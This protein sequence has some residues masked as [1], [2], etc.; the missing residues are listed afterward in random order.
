MTQ[1]EIIT[2]LLKK[3]DS[4]QRTVDEQTKFIMKMVTYR[5]EREDADS[6]ERFDRFLQIWHALEQNDA[7]SKIASSLFT[8][9]PAHD[10]E[11]TH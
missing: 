8:G 9:R 11:Q 1:D 6:R 4:L 10:S 5:D 2:D 3:V 7:I